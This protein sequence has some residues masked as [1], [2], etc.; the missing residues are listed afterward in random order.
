MFT[1]EQLDDMAAA[2][3]AVGREAAI[4]RCMDIYNFAKCA[5]D[6]PASRALILLCGGYLR[7][8]LDRVGRHDEATLEP[9]RVTISAIW[10]GLVLDGEIEGSDGPHIDK[11]GGTSNVHP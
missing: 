5:P 7:Y 10:C 3:P 1:P 2:P 8:D 9:L 11:D 4:G 6:S